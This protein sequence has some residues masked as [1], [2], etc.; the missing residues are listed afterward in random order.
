MDRHGR[1][2]IRL[3]TLSRRGAVALGGLLAVAAVA[4]T[5]EGQ[6]PP[7]DAQANE[8]PTTEQAAETTT[9]EA[10]QEKPSPDL[11]HRK[12]LTGDWSGSRTKLEDHGL[13]FGLWYN[14]Y[15]GY[16]AHGGL[17]T[18][19]R[20]SG[21]YDLIITADF[22]KM[23]VL[24]GGKFLAFGQGWM[25]DDRNVNNMVGALGEP[26][27]DADG[28]K[29]IYVDQAWYEQ[30]FLERKIALRIGYLDQQSI[31]DRNA[32]ANSED[33]QFMNTYLDNNNAIVPLTIGLGATVFL[34]ATE[35]L[36]FIVGA[37]DG[38]A[39]IFRGGFDTTFHDGADFFGYFE[40]D[41]KVKLPTD[42]GPLPGTYRL[43][44]VYDPRTRAR[45]IDDIGGDGAGR[46]ETGDVGFY[47]SFDQ[48]VYRESPD[49][50]QGLG[51][52]IRYGRRDDGDIN[53][54]SDFW[55]TGVQYAG[56]IP[57]RDKDV[58]GFGVYSLHSS[59]RYRREVDSEFLRETGYELYYRIQVTPWLQV[60]ADSQYIATPGAL[61]TADD[62]FVMGL[63]ARVTF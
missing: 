11:W 2:P 6:K 29:P 23:G 8:Q 3:A 19:V 41:F 42:R 9:A 44:L 10:P 58:A 12:Y 24:P 52:F 16:N 59:H 7:Q 60:T 27:D 57:G 18:G 48:M 43:G 51:C 31:V 55:S 39:R 26:F 21:S 30:G 33:T 17:D 50:D 1:Y 22:D 62:A 13:T 36:S 20:G 32:Y 28:T 38:E 54:I 4:D 25:G 35:W 61:S 63:R 56:L 45:F 40:T 47:S 14:A 46:F 49:D 5:Q 34:E 15:L 53:R 37:A